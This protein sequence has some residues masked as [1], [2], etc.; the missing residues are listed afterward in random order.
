MSPRVAL[1][2]DEPISTGILST[3]V[4]IVNNYFDGLEVT[5]VHKFI[6]Y[7]IMMAYFFEQLDNWNFGFIAPALQES[8]HLQMTDI[9]TIVFWYF[10]GMTS[11]GFLGGVIS[12]FIGRRK[13]FLGLNSNLFHCVGCQRAYRQF[14]H[15]YN[16]PCANGIRRVLPHGDLAGLYCRNGARRVPR[17][18]AGPSCGG[19]ILCGPGNCSFVQIDHPIGT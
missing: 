11:G 10:I 6:F 14:Y 18:M 4:K 9:A 13:T 12:D 8:W 3:K 1:K 5:G 15:F 19:R 7:I 2:I 16:F 17:E